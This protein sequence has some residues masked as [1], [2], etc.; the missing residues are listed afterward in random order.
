MPITTRMVTCA[1]CGQTNEMVELAPTNFSG[2]PDLDTRPTAMARET[3]AYQVMHCPDCDYCA[4]N[5]AEAPAGVAEFIRSS[6]YQLQLHDAALPALANH[7]LC[8]AL[9]SAHLGDPGSAGWHALSAAWVCDDVRTKAAPFCRLRAVTYWRQALAE[10]KPFY[11]EPGST[12]GDDDAEARGLQHVV[13]ADVLR[14]SAQFPM[15]L[16]ECESALAVEQPPVV[17]ALLE[18]ELKL[19]KVFD[20]A[21]HNLS[22]YSAPQAGS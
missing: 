7:F 1:V 20:V 14:R 8:R 3:L 18:I 16:T 15:A 4:A 11:S 13:M 12:D 6:A 17:R 9:I 5:L 22:E 21:C 10:G 19:V 2:S